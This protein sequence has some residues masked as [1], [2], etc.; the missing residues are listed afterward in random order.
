MWYV[1]AMF[2]G[3]WFSKLLVLFAS[4]FV[5]ASILAPA[6]QLSDGTVYAGQPGA[7]GFNGDNGK[8]TSAELSSPAGLAFDSKGNLY[9]ADTGNNRIRKVAAGTGII[10]TFAGEAPS[11][12][13]V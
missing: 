2:Q 5:S 6:Q 12:K 10:T 7:T 9:I 11:L 1:G 3:T 13:T 8:T 4:A